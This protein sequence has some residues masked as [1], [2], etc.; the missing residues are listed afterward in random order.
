MKKIVSSFVI[1]LIITVSSCKK[2][3]GEGGN[4]TITGYVLVEEWN[5]TFTIHDSANDHPGAD[6]DVYI[7]YGNDITYGNKVKTSP[8]GIFEFKYLRPGSYTVY[9]YSKDPNPSGKVA[10][11][12]KV[13]ITG[14]K[15]TV[16]T[17]TIT[18][19]N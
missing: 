5:S 18:V 17:G 4:S 16:N 7:V 9:V 12:R 19:K 10:I 1:A 6:E 15:Q 14:K 2:T 13:E 11:E 3:A 8:A